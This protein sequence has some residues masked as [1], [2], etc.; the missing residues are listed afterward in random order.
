MPAY[1]IGLLNDVD[2]NAEIIEY[3]TQIESTMAP[4]G[5]R[6]VVHGAHAQV[7]EGTMAM[8]CVILGFPSMEQARLWYASEAYQSILPL[9]TRN[10]TGAVFFIEGVPENYSADTLIEKV[11]NAA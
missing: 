11:K 5:G 4:F 2:F 9:R 10:S 6:Y 7:V 8:D 1:V 3:V